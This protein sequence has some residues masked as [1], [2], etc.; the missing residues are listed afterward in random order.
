MTNYSNWSV[1]V[2]NG[3]AKQWN[4]F[5]KQ[6]RTYMES[7]VNEYESV[8]VYSSVEGIKFTKVELKTYYKNK[9]YYK[10]LHVPMSMAGILSH[11]L[12]KDILDAF[13]LEFRK[14]FLKNPELPTKNGLAGADLP[15]EMNNPD[16][17][18]MA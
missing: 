15:D 1:V 14:E 4:A 2:D 13:V 16:F 17:L 9:E 12:V 5:T 11:A 10:E 8:T 3:T 7:V 6:I 18:E